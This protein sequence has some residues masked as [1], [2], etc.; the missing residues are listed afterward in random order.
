VN[1]KEKSEYINTL[2]FDLRAEYVISCLLGED[3]IS[4]KDVLA[5]FDGPFKRKWSFDI[6]R[7]EVEDF[8]NGDESLS[9]HLNRAGIYDGLPEALFH[10][11]S[12]NKNASGDDMAKESMK[13]K[14]EEKSIRKFFRPF[15]HEIFFQ[16]VNVVEKETEVLRRL[17]SDFLN[18]LIP[19]FW[20]IDRKIP[21]LYASRLIKLLPYAHQIAG[22]YNIT[23]RCLE[24]ILGEDVSIELDPWEPEELNGSEVEDKP[25]GGALGWSKLGKDMVIGKKASG[26][27]G[28]LVVKVGPLKNTHVRDFFE[29]RAADRLLNCFY[30]YFM[31]VELDVETQLASDKK[32]KTFV[33]DPETKNSLLGYS[34]VL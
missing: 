11:F 16:N 18:G 23:A 7:S 12:D 24:S 9:V 17:Y 5:V 21:P 4:Q 30:G 10:S 3:N 28:R 8:E 32:Q 2:L 15:E 34:T 20:K 13:I 19:G 14:G 22:N 29:N 25:R 33:L 6:D 31:P 27:I 1:L 26:F